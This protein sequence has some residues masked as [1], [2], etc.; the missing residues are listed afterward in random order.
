LLAVTL[1]DY[2]KLKDAKPPRPS[3]DER[4]PGVLTASFP[5]PLNTVSSFA[6]KAPLTGYRVAIKNGKLDVQPSAKPRSDAAPEG[7]QPMWAFAVVF[8]FSLAGLGIWSARRRSA[9]C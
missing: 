4:A 7:P 8:A 6:F 5:P 3:I 1:A 9:L 2:D